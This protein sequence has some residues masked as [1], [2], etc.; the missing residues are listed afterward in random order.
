MEENYNEESDEGCFLEID[1]EY[2]KKLLE[3]HNDLPFLSEK[4]E[5]GKIKNQNMVKMKNFVIC[6]QTALLST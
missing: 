4:I 2:P 6:I 1:V 3:L 5:L